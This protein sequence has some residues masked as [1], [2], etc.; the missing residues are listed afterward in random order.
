MKTI[1]LLCPVLAIIFIAVGCK[2]KELS[3]HE[4]AATGDIQ[5]VQLLISKGIDVNAKKE[6]RTPLH[7]A[8]R[9]G[10]ME[11]AELLLDNGADVDGKRRYSITPLDEA[12]RNGHRE[13]A[14][15]L[16]S[17]GADDNAKTRPVNWWR[18]HRAA[19]KGNK[20]RV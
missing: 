10:H 9:H 19:V 3:L 8:A 12:I 14:E 5:Q 6:D 17:K 4:V 20:D 7:Y 15:L 18:L 1:R 13:V 2:K 11:V 16:I